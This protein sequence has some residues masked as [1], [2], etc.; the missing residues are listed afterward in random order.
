MPHRRRYRRAGRVPPG[1]RLRLA[2]LREERDDVAFARS[3]ELPGDGPPEWVDLIPVGPVHARDGRSWRNDDPEAVIRASLARAGTTDLPIDWEHQA[4]KSEGEAPAAGWFR[5]LRVRD[6]HVQARIEWTSRAADQIDKRE[7]RYISPVFTFDEAGAVTALRG[8]GLTNNPALDLP[9]LATSLEGTMTKEQLAKLREALG[10]AKDAAIDAV[11]AAAT[12]AIARAAGLAKVAEKLGLAK[13]AGTDD[14][15]EAAGN[16]RAGTAG[17]VKVAEK[18]G[19]AKDAG[20]DDVVAAAHKAPSGGDFVPRAEFDRVSQGLAALQ[21]ETAEAAAAT[22][23]DDAV[24]AGKIAP[25]QRDWSLAYAKDD[26]D[27]FSKFVEG[28]PVIVSPGRNPAPATAPDAPLTEDERAVCRAMG[29]D[30]KTFIAA[31]K[32]DMEGRAA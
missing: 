9:A 8:A 5:E 26:P 31:R 21:T 4:Y 29:L 20:A 16:A 28:A 30:E 19:L 11:L 7:Y 13:D 12:A 27:G 6:G 2:V 32:A 25:A 10:L 22:A 24:K 14:V 17:L 18:L 1:T 3:V 23:V 15:V